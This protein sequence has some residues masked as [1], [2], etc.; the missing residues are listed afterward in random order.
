MLAFM[1]ESGEIVHVG[2]GVYFS[3]D[4]YDRLVAV[5]M[6]ILDR[7][8]SVT[9]AEFRDA[10]GTTRKYAQAFL[11]HLDARRITRRQGDVRVRGRAAPA[12]V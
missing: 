8:G 2:N 3:A 5:V 6:D 9:M 4:A 7:Q 1:G 11:E 10:A 12:C